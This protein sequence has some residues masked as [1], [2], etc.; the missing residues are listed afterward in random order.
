MKKQTSYTHSH[1]Y[2]DGSLSEGD[3][4]EFAGKRYKLVGLLDA[5][6]LIL[7]PLAGNRIVWAEIVS[8]S[9]DQIKV[10]KAAPKKK[11]LPRPPSR[12]STSEVLAGEKKAKP[13]SKIDLVGEQFETAL[14]AVSKAGESSR[15]ALEERVK[16]TRPKLRRSG[17]Q[18][19]ATLRGRV[20][21]AAA[22]TSA[23]SAADA[24][25]RAEQ[26]RIYLRAGNKR[27]LEKVVAVDKKG[28]FKA[29]LKL[30]GKGPWRLFAETESG[31]KAKRTVKKRAAKKAAR[32]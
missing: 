4:I 15:K 8:A 29:K 10:I 20:E 27:L 14:G 21:S 26:V 3:T 5:G 7:A 13:S 6:Q 9:S 12:A 25:A 16:L 31:A 30:P 2:S 28:R 24:S 19:R 1:G 22:S 11:I 32:K 18:L 17:K 23:Q